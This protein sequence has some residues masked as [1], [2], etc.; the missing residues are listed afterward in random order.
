[1]RLGIENNQFYLSIQTI[2]RSTAMLFNRKL[3]S[4]S[5]WVHKF[6]HICIPIL[7]KISP[8]VINNLYRIH[9]TSELLHVDIVIKLFRMKYGHLSKLECQYL[10]LIICVSD[11]TWHVQ[12]FY[13][14]FKILIRATLS[15]HPSGIGLKYMVSHIPNLRNL[16]CKIKLEK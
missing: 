6:S 3:T 7:N 2:Q 13:L 9:L 15:W 4:L 10:M 5:Y 16:T 11:I 8:L 1:M 12:F 14:F